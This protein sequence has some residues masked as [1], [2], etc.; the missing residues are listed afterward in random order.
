MG[1]YT[2]NPISSIRQVSVITGILVGSV[3]WN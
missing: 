1:M 3:Q 2:M